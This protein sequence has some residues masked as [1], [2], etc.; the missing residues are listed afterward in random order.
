MFGH[1]KVMEFYC[2]LGAGTL[3]VVITCINVSDDL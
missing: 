3:C 1:G 2:V